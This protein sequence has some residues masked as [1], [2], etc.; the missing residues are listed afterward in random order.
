MLISYIGEPGFD[1]QLWLP[2]MQTLRG[3]SDG[4]SQWI[5]ATHKG[6]LGWVPSSLLWLSP[7]HYRPGGVNQPT[8][9]HTW[10]FCV[11]QVICL[12]NI[13]NSIRF[14]IFLNLGRHRDRVSSHPLVHPTDTCQDQDWKQSRSLIWGRDSTTWAITCRLS[15]SILAGSWTC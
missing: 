14:F 12:M 7:A 10:F 15:G 4:L 8:G 1:S 13:C 2:T 11:S 9:A 3:N 6:D 5:S